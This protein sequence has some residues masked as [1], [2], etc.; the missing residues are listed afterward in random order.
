[1]KNE[2]YKNLIRKVVDCSENNNW[3]DAVAEW[4][5]DDC[6][7]DFRCSS[8]CLCGKENIRYLYTIKNKHNSIT[9]FPIGSSCINKFGRNELREK[10]ALIE[11][12]FKLLH[13]VED[14]MYLSLSSELFSRKLLLWLYQEGAFDT[15]YNNYKGTQDYEFMLKMFNKRDKSSINAKQQKK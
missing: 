14:G 15:E 6:E 3:D 8:K 12:E 9:L 5:I 11:G 7:E 4:Y 13:A 1:M 10:T 2:Y